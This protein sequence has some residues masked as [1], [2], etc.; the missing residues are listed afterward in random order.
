MSRADKVLWLA[1]LLLCAVLL[2]WAIA[3]AVSGWLPQGDNAVIAAKVHDVFSAHPPLQ[4][5][6][7]TSSLTV[8]DVYAH[9]PGPIEFYL[10]AIP[11]AITGFA[12]I[13]LLVGI[14]VVQC[15]FVVAAIRAARATGGLVGGWLMAGIVAALLAAFGD[16]LVR[17]LNLYFAVLG[18]LAVITLGWR[19]LVGPMD[20]LIAYVVCASI[21]AQPHLSMLAPVA[22][23]TL[24]VIV[25][26]TGRHRLRSGTWFPPHW[27][28]RGVVALLVALALWLPVIVE[29]VAFSPGNLGQLVALWSGGAGAPGS[30]QAPGWSDVL[31]QVGAMIVPWGGRRVQAAAAL[32]LLVVAIG[33]CVRLAMR[34]RRREGHDRNDLVISV[35]VAT[36]LAATLAAVWTTSRIGNL[37]QLMYSDALCAAPVSLAVFTGWWLVRTLARLRWPSGIARVSPRR[38][39]HASLAALLALG[40]IGLLT[41]ASSL[42]GTFG[43]TR[44]HTELAARS[45]QLVQAELKQPPRPVRVEYQ[46]VYS[47]SS[48]GPAVIAQLLADGRP[49]YFDVLW[50][51]PQDD[52]SHRLTHAPGDAVRV[53][54]RDASGDAPLPTWPNAAGCAWNTIA[55]PSDAAAGTRIQVCVLN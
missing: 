22:A 9:H 55:A 19:L 5:Q 4:G 39:F 52:D 35:A 54:L 21:A 25:V 34:L 1:T 33:C 30:G 23:V 43:E 11:Y 40:V 51:N 46:G 49:V 37:P 27:T 13:G 28:R 47:W 18:L 6:R 48:I 8:P 50:P 3:L 17:P 45:V 10:L 44:A 41:P 32:A 31:A 20:A 7:S 26:R 53:L 14:A 29:I 38:T 16:L 36:A 24:T 12:P 42:A 15:G 2:T